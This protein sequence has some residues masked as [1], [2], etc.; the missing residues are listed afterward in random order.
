MQFVF[1]KTNLISMRQIITPLLAIVI[2]IS[3]CSKQDRA[4][5]ALAVNEQGTARLEAVTPEL[6]GRYNGTFERNGRD[7]VPVSLLFRNDGTYEGSS[8]SKNYPAIC[9][10]TF[11]VSG[12]T[13]VV[14]DMC[15]WD[16]SVDPS[17][18]FTG[19]WNI[20]FSDETHVRIW[21]TN[22]TVTDEY[23][24]GRVNK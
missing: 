13:L 12:S 3:A 6:Y 1:S 19:T 14:K 20:S 5:E 11:Q 16:S 22:G 7:S 15:T 18:I 4:E 10:G 2:F 17:L 9:S 23:I 21:R 24:L 8:N